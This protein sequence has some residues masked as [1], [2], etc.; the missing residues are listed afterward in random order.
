MM[1]SIFGQRREDTDHKA[2]FIQFKKRVVY[3]LPLQESSRIS[4]IALRSIRI[5]TI[6]NTWGA[7]NPLGNAE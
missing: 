2:V 5:I 3:T 7:T 4:Y 1:I 6:G